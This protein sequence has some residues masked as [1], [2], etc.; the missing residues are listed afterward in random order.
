MLGCQASPRAM[1]VRGEGRQNWS[2][3]CPPQVAIRLQLQQRSTPIWGQ[4]SRCHCANCCRAPFCLWASPRLTGWQPCAHTG[5]LLGWANRGLPRILQGLLDCVCIGLQRVL[6]LFLPFSHDWHLS[7]RSCS[8]RCLLLH[9][10]SVFG[11]FLVELQAPT[12]SYDC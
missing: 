7:S 5:D 2:V 1:S 12:G 3:A 6:L 8:R 10:L 4:H 11:H 9:R